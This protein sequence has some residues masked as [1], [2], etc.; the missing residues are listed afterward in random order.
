[1]GNDASNDD[2]DKSSSLEEEDAE[3]A[4][5]GEEEEVASDASSSKE[6]GGDVSAKD[7]EDIVEH[8]EGELKNENER[9]ENTMLTPREVSRQ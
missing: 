6:D 7:K 1:M 2:E 3:D 4:S 8:G 5:S 9:V